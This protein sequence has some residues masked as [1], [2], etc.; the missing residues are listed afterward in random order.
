MKHL[1][2]TATAFLASLFASSAAMASATSVSAA[3]VFGDRLV[4]Q[5]TEGSKVVSLKYNDSYQLTEVTTKS[6]YATSS[7]IFSYEGGTYNGEPYDVK[8]EITDPSQHL[9]CYLTTDEN[10]FATKSVE[11]ETEAGES[12]EYETYMYEYD[13]DGHLV[14]VTETGIFYNETVAF[15]YINGDIV[16]ATKVDDEV[17]NYKVSYTSSTVSTPINNVGKLMN[18]DAFGL[19]NFENTYF[20]YAGLLGTSTEHLPLLSIESDNDGSDTTRYDWTL[21]NDGYPIQ[22]KEYEGN[23]LEDI[24]NYSWIGTAAIAS[25]DIDD[26]QSH[27]SGYYDI[28]GFRHDVPVKGLNIQRHTD[29]TT[30]KIMIRQ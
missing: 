13:A 16:S 23:E 2:L 14:K 15:E 3:N 29:G 11:I 17:E 22:F 5:I 18:F 30:S 6:P 1:F 8:V 27:V 26:A 10:G 9:I 4:S 19:D 7:A 20:Y 24:M 25:I 21:N 28:N 12:A